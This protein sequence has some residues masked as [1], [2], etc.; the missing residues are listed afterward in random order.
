MPVEQRMLCPRDNLP[1]FYARN[2]RLTALIVE[3]LHCPVAHVS[4][5]CIAQRRSVIRNAMNEREAVK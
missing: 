5:S 2:E 4:V 1:V 3:H